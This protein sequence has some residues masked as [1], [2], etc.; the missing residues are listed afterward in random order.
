MFWTTMQPGLTRRAEAGYSPGLG[1]I[2]G[3]GKY[4]GAC[5]GNFDEIEKTIF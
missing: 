4:G 1:S 2:G 5:M 3:S